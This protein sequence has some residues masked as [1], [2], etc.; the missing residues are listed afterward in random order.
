MIP[1]VSLNFSGFVLLTENMERRSRANAFSKRGISS[2]GI[3][4]STMAKPYS[5]RVELSRL[6]K[7]LEEVRPATV[8]CSTTES[9]KKGK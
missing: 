1:K 5:S 8:T 9:S 4:F 6:E 3:T 7:V 2:C